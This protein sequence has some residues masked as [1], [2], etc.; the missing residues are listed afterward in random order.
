MK[1]INELLTNA[2]KYRDVEKKEG[3]CRWFRHSRRTEYNWCHCLDKIQWLLN[4]IRI[5]GHVL[6]EE[7][8]RIC[9]SFFEISAQALGLVT[10][11]CFCG[12]LPEHQLQLK[13]STFSC[14]PYFSA[15]REDLWFFF[16]LL[17]NSMSKTYL[18]PS[19]L[20]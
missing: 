15:E 5:K 7:I 4:V 1:R 6:S 17:T 9:S 14:F 10:C 13:H 19:C 11:K 2:K 12:L 20:I 8:L 16:F 18:T 3:N